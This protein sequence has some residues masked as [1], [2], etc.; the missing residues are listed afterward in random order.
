MCHVSNKEGRCIQPTKSKSAKIKTFDKNLKDHR[1]H[2][3][4]NKFKKN[5]EGSCF[6]NI[7]K[8]SN[9]F[10]GICC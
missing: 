2:V 9:R 10:D 1:K 4:I 8:S 3:K 7:F 5:H 6:R